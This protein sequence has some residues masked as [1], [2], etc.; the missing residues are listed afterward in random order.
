MDLRIPRMN[1]L[2]LSFQPDRSTSKR[3]IYLVTSGLLLRRGAK[4][5]GRFEFRDVLDGRFTIAGVHDYPPALPWYVYT[6]TQAPVHLSVM[7]LY[8]SRLARLAR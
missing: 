5:R 6:W 8:Q 7:R 2:T 4:Q 1:L 3:Q